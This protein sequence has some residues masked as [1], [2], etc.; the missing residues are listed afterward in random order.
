[1]FAW[2]RCTFSASAYACSWMCVSN[3]CVCQPDCVCVCF[4]CPACILDSFPVAHNRLE[5]MLSVSYQ[6]CAFQFWTVLCVLSPK[7][8]VAQSKVTRS[9]CCGEPKS[10]SCPDIVCLIFSPKCN[11]A[12]ATWWKINWLFLFVGKVLHTLSGKKSC[13]FSP[14]SSHT[15]GIV[16]S[17]SQFI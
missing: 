8:Q 3:L 2:Y 6:R 9:S 10:V 4:V 7:G 16:F 15:T 17:A 5:L 11:W 12:A 14:K 13:F 1:M